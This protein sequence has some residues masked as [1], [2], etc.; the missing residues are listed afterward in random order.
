LGGEVVVRAG[1][2]CKRKL[3]SV[4]IDSDNLKENI[5]SNRVAKE[6]SPL[7][8]PTTKRICREKTGTEW[9]TFLDV[10]KYGEEVLQSRKPRA[11]HTI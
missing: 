9:Q 11:L 8:V 2:T 3:D 10:M 4:D 7:G 6:L 1:V 5:S